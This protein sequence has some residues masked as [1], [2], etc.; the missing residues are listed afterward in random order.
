MNFWHNWVI[1]IAY[2]CLCIYSH[3]FILFSFFF[4]SLQACI[5]FTIF[6]FTC[7]KHDCWL[8]SMM[9][10]VCL[11]FSSSSTFC[12]VF[13][14][15]LYNVNKKLSVSNKQGLSLIRYHHELKFIYSSNHWSPPTPSPTVVLFLSCTYCMTHTV[16]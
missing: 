8:I 6:L 16:N 7:H 14:N 1:S 9:V 11:D 3:V 5:C 13:V 12:F 4:F 2:F 10:W 15:V